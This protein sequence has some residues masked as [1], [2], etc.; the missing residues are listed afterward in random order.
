[1]VD[2]HVYFVGE[3]N[4]ESLFDCQSCEEAIA[5]AT[6]IHPGRTIRSVYRLTFGDDG[7]VTRTTEYHRAACFAGI[8]RDP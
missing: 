6:R 8:G 4:A 2:Y 7:E 5:R 3:I 1:M